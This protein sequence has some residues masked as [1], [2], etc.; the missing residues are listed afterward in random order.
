MWAVE[1]EEDED[2]PIDH[3]AHLGGDFGGKAD[4][5]EKLWEDYE[6]KGPE[7]RAAEIGEATEDNDGEDED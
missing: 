2:K 3:L 4:E 5:T 6:A 7:D 1:H